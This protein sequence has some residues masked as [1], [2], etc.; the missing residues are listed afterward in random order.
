MTLFTVLL[1]FCLALRFI[2]LQRNEEIISNGSAQF[3]LHIFEK[4]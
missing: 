4:K 1:L 3:C 2:D